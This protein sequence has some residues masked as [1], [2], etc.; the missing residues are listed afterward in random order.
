[1][2]TG[3]KVL[4]GFVGFIALVVLVALMLPS[5]WSAKTSMVINAPP[6][7]IH[8]FVDDL[9][10]WPEWAGPVQPDPTLKYEYSGAENGVGAVQSWKSSAGRGF[11]KILS[12]DPATGIHFENAYLSDEVNGT[13]IISYTPDGDKT[14]VTWK[15]SGAVMPIIGTMFISSIET[16]VREFYRHAL[17]ELKNL[18]EAPEPA[19]PPQ[20]P[21][22]APQ[23]PAGADAAAP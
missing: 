21:T 9:H 15:G 5:Q 16:G 17:V 6:S 19:P 22:D 20:P 14:R 10:R 11:T 23:P 18:A 13:G 12:S 8:V 3:I 2:S 1:M 7:R 4:I